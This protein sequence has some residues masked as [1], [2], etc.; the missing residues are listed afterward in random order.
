MTAKIKS[1]SLLQSGHLRQLKEAGF[2]KISR[3][4]L[5]LCRLRLF[6]FARTKKRILTRRPLSLLSF[7][8]RIRKTA[9]MELTLSTSNA[10][11]ERGAARVVVR[12]FTFLGS[13]I[14]NSAEGR[15]FNLFA[16]PIGT[17]ISQPLYI[18]PPSRAFWSLVTVQR[19]TEKRR[20]GIA[21]SLRPRLLE[22]DEPLAFAET[23]V[24]RDRRSLEFHVEQA[25]HDQNRTAAMQLLGRMIFLER[26]SDDLMNM[27]FVADIDQVMADL[28]AKPNVCSDTAAQDFAYSTLFTTAFDNSVPLS[29]WLVSEG[30]SLKAQAS[31]QSRGVC[32]VVV[33]PGMHCGLRILAAAHAGYSVSLED[34]Q[35]DAG[36]KQEQ[37][38]WIKQQELLSFLSPP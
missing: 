20:I 9:F 17:A 15:P 23:L 13:E 33:T 29:K 25:Q 7:V 27:R 24:S 6:D 10:V 34:V 32:K 4:A 36:N 11:T 14:K 35:G 5:V 22:H 38:P 16:D 26:R 18:D 28:A 8:G 31:K 1:N 21:G 2:V 30:I 37:I 12:Y 19:Q 3:G